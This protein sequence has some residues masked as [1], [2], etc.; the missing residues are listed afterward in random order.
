MQKRHTFYCRCNKKQIGFRSTGRRVK[1]LIGSDYGNELEPLLGKLMSF[2]HVD[3]RAASRQKLI[4]GP[5]LDCKKSRVIVKV[6]VAGVV[7]KASASALKIYSDACVKWRNFYGVRL[8]FY[9]R[10]LRSRFDR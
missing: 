6:A 9:E 10:N 4:S 5:E 2:F 7:S 8:L 3:W 1:S